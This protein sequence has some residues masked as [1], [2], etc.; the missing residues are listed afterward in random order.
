MCAN[1]PGYAHPPFSRSIAPATNIAL[2]RSYF[3][4]FYSLL[5]PFIDPITREKVKFLN[6]GDATAF[7]P[8]S[9]LQSM[10]DGE[11]DFQ[12]DHKTYFPALDKLCAERRVANLERW[13]KYGGGRCGLSEAVIRGAVT[14]NGKE[15]DA[16]V[17]K[18]KVGT[19]A[20]PSEGKAEPDQGEAEAEAEAEAKA[21]GVGGA[22]KGESEEP[23]E[24]VEGV[25]DLSIQDKDEQPA[26]APS[27][28]DAAA[29]V[30]VEAV[31]PA[32]AKTEPT[33]ASESAPVMTKAEAPVAT[34]GETSTAPPVRGGLPGLAPPLETPGD[35]QSFALAPEA[36]V[37]AVE[38]AVE[39]KM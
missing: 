25:E 18:G 30:E 9:Q 23:K 38:K 13:R 27:T 15:G 1:V 28:E 26:P 10:F 11:V 8:P 17:K 37:E 20:V 39:T 31:P 7:V 4:S 33:L 35:D 22:E 14:P 3:H 36:S 16:V 2:S 21:G 12:Y 24:P 32:E 5:S 34:E 19:G 6:G 29:K